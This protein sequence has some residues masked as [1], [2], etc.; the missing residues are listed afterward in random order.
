MRPLGLAVAAATL[1]LF[2]PGVRSVGA[3]SPCRN[4]AIRS[5]F[6]GEPLQG[7]VPI[8]GSARID[9]FQF[10]KVEWAPN[11]APEQW[12]A[13][14]TTKP[15]PVQN[16]LLDEWDTKRLPD[17]TYRLKLTA[18]DAA[19][20]EACRV[21]VTDLVLANRATPTATPPPSAEP[22]EVL[23]ATFTPEGAIAAA[24]AP[25]EPATEMVAL[26]TDTAAVPAVETAGTAGATEAVGSAPVDSEPQAEPVVA[27]AVP[28][29][30]IAP[31]GSAAD[32]LSPSAWARALGARGWLD[33]FITGFAAALM[34]ITILLLINGL[35]R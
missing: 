17:G 4:V 16:G 14:S 34:A 30:P 8:L 5:P 25:L 9:S 26:P 2:V 24:T 21:L 29:T 19:G 23:V 28:I 20:Q 31:A 3:Q 32:A 6:R 12:N 11:Y 1:A 15:Q 7:R 10:Y 22:T 13:V 18:V 27:T 35:R 33:A